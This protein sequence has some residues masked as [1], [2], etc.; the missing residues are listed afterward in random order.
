MH[1]TATFNFLNEGIDH[2]MN[3]LKQ[4]MSYTKYMELYTYAVYLLCLLETSTDGLILQRRI[5]L[6]YV[7]QDDSWINGSG[8]EE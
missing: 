2:I 8:S 6:L 3:K 5:Q 7:K 1:H 4:G